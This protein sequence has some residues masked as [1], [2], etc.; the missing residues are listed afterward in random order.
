MNDQ[1]KNKNPIYYIGGG[2]CCGKSTIA[3]LL[4][5][6]YDF[7]YY[8][9]DDYL[10]PYVSKLSLDG[11]F[12]AKHIQTLSQ[13]ETWMR[14]PNEQ[15]LEELAL[16]NNMFDYAKKDIEF[17]S[18]GKMILAEG[19]GFLPNIMKSEHISSNNYICIVPTKEFQIEKYSK[20][21]WIK[22][23]LEGISD[24]NL[25]FSNWMERD[26]IFSEH[27]LAQ[28]QLLGYKTIVVDGKKSVDEILAIVEYTF[29]LKED[30]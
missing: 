10:E 6:K 11:H 17:I 3:E 21:S 12:L 18:D 29:R 25:A 30:L 8:K 20:R 16:Y 2:T 15:F 1:N 24:Q 5:A 26:V 4:C 27:V 9:L 14:T 19:A 7:T 13:E 28:A 22:N 23:Y